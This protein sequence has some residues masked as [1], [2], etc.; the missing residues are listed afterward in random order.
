MKYAEKEDLQKAEQNRGRK[1][2]LET[3]D[4]GQYKLKTGQVTEKS[5]ETSIL[6]RE[7]WNRSSRGK[8]TKAERNGKIL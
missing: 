6:T 7:L 1:E 2:T 8:R 4:A 5:T 3:K